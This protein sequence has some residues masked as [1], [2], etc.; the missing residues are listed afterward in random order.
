MYTFAQAARNLENRGKERHSPEKRPPVRLQETRDERTLTSNT[1][2]LET[3]TLEELGRADVVFTVWSEVLGDTVLFVPDHYKPAEGD[4]AT[5][6]AK[7][8]AVLLLVPR[9]SIRAVHAVKKV[10]GGRLLWTKKEEEK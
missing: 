7:E 8:L 4:P 3:M 2:L 9:D 1:P 5:F 6:S 10:L